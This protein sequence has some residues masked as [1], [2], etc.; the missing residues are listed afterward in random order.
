MARPRASIFEEAEDPPPAGTA[1]AGLDLSGFAPRAAPD[2]HA[3]PAAAV[4]AV[5]EAARFRSREPAAALKP[6]AAPE[7]T[8]QV[9]RTAAPQAHPD[10]HAEA[11]RVP[12]RY[13]TGR[14]VQFNVKV[15]QATIDAFYAI[16]DRQG[17]VLGETLEHA[18]VALRRALDAEPDSRP[19]TALSP[20]RDP[21]RDKAT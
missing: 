13:R 16:A 14:N 20:A 3:P 6:Q 8:P 11:R 17:W 18:L 1:A 12:R 19:D 5:A 10:P 4:R 15:S 2:P 21:A 9:H 7:A